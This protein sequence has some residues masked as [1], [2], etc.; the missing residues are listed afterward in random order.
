MPQTNDII[1]Y[2]LYVQ[3]GIAMGY[4]MYISIIMVNI[5]YIY[6]DIIVIPVMGYTTISWWYI[7]LSIGNHPEYPTPSEFAD[8][9]PSPMLTAEG[10]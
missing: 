9:S 10:R 3:I 7:P 5:V 4:M 6:I 8:C 1:P 2:L